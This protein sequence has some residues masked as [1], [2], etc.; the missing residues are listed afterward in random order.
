MLGI[1]LLID[2][3]MGREVKDRQALHDAA[4]TFFLGFIGLLCI[5]VLISIFV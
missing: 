4:Q 5:L 1:K 2:E 3:F